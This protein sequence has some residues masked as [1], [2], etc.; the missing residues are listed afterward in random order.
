MELT[1]WASDHLLATVGITLGFLTL[2]A[3]SVLGIAGWLLAAV[4]G[5]GGTG[6]LGSLLPLFVV[7]LVVGVPVSVVGVVAVAVGLAARASSAVSGTTEIAG[8]RLGRVA[9]YVERENEYARMVGLADLVENFDTRSAEQ[10]AD[11]RTERLKE[12][13]VEGEISE[14]EFEQRMQTV[15][16][17]EG[18]QREGVST[19]D[20]ELRA[21]ERN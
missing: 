20:D 8:I 16:D 6:A 17:E 10:R 11:D 21:A 4:L 5:L 7:G 18:V 19:I 13:Y 9:S 2:T 12:R 15:L 3:V 14:H 1:D